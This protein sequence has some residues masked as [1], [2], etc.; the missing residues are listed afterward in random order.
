MPERGDSRAPPQTAVQGRD[1]PH[2]RPFVQVSAIPS[3][4]DEG[5]HLSAAA[6]TSP[7][8]VALMNSQEIE[9]TVREQVPLVV[10]MSEGSVSGLVE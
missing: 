7:T 1:S 10:L 4:A 9:P 6:P 5:R 3:R 2:K 8:P